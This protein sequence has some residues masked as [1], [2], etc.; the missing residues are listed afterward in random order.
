MQV[1]PTRSY[2]C[3]YHP[4]DTNGY[5]VATESGIQPFVQVK[6][7][8]AEHAARAAHAVTGCPISNVE[9]V[10]GGAA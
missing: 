3:S 1:T 6:A 5:P 9:R 10:E 7:S 4:K 8:S 2:R